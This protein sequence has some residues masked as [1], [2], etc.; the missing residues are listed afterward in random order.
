MKYTTRYTGT[1][2]ARRAAALKD[3]AEYVNSPDMW[4]KL[5]NG[6]RDVRDNEGLRSAIRGGRFLTMMIGIQ[7]A[8]AA[9]VIMFALRHKG[10][11]MNNRMLPFKP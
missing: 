2:Q 5:I 6:I 8:P 1:K 11:W 10:H 4:T 3:A 9:A 7:G